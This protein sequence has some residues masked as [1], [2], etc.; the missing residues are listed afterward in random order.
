MKYENFSS[1]KLQICVFFCNFAPKMEQLYHQ[2]YHWYD[3]NRRILPWRETEDPYAIWLS[4]IILQQ[5]R[6]AHGLEYYMRFVARWPRVEDLAAADEAEVLR[7]WQGLGYYSRARNLHKAAQQIVESQKSK[8]ENRTVMFF[9]RLLRISVRYPEW[10]TI[11]PEPSLLL[12]TTCP[13]LPWTAMYIGWWHDCW[14]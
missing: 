12:R 10:E 1:K 11:P 9:R 8:A 7:E 2:L 5:T 3:S 14:T 4:E 13:T 6:V